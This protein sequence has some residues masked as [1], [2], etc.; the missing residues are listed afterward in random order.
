MSRDENA[1]P[2]AR[3]G[4]ETSNAA[5][6]SARTN[7]SAARPFLHRWRSAVYN[8]RL[9]PGARIAL[10]A[11]AEFADETGGN[12]YPSH[13]TVGKL[14]GCNEKTVRA[15]LDIAFEAG[16][17]YRFQTSS[18]KSWAHYRYQLLIPD[19]ADTRRPTEVHRADKSSGASQ[20]GKDKTSAPLNDA[21]EETS[22]PKDDCCGSFRQMARNISPDGAEEITGELAFDLAHRT[23]IEEDALTSDD[24]VV[25]VWSIAVDF[26]K[27]KTDKSDKQI[28]SFIGR[29]R[30]NLC[31]DDKRLVELIE[32]AKREEIADVF[33][34]LSAATAGSRSRMPLPLYRSDAKSDDALLEASLARVG[35]SA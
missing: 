30:K 5:R 7:D 12:C 33:E 22:A 29:L 25:P 27:T 1:P 26:L 31:N 32:T 10:L 15:N 8:S 9:K 16:F 24:K 34:W 20:D 11:L 19:S 4:V 13:D 23:G 35:A 2:V 3:R 17:L 6:D 14:C 28:R 18:G 21:P